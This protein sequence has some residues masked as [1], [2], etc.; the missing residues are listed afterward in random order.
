MDTSKYWDDH[1]ERWDAMD[2]VLRPSERDVSI[3]NYEAPPG[4][5]I[6]LGAT[7]ELIRPGDTVWDTSPRMLDKA[8]AMH[9]NAEYVRCPWNAMGVSDA[10]NVV[11]DG[12]LNVLSCREQFKV[13]QAVRRVLKPGGRF[14]TRVYA[15]D[16]VGSFG[17][18]RFRTLVD[19]TDQFGDVVLA[20]AYANGNLPEAYN[21]P[22]VVYNFPTFTQ[23]IERAHLAGLDCIS[24]RASSSYPILVFE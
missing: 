13:L 12:S 17:P 7:V 8:R 3:Y 16:R 9:P 2:A 19:R 10:A 14:V 20:D 11:G 22:G 15:R 1:A 23:L 24:H 5:R 21:A 18:S 4:G 6:V